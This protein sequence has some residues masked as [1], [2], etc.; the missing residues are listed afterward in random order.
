MLRA[1]E[2]TCRDPQR[3]ASLPAAVGEPTGLPQSHSVCPSFV[4]VSPPQQGF[5]EPAAKQ[6]LRRYEVEGQ[7]RAQQ[8][9]AQKMPA[10]SAGTERPGAP[11]V[12]RVHRIAQKANGTHVTL[13]RFDLSHN[14][15]LGRGGDS[16]LEHRIPCPE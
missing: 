11:Q 12:C 10:P 3:L 4:Q 16:V 7:T 9:T 5:G 2:P 6:W 15:D 13:W 1:R 8:L 14:R